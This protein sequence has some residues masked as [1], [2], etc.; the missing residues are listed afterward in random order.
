V[1]TTPAGREAWRLIGELWFG[2][3]MQERFHAA[4]ATAAISPPQLKALLSLEPGEGQ[5]MRALA[6]TWHCDASWVT[7]LVDG[8]EQRGYVERQA[9]P[10][11]RRIKAVALTPLGEKIK[12]E[13]LAV[14]HE[15]PPSLD[16]LSA[17]EQSDLRDLMAKV[18]Q[19]ISGVD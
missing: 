18:A 11:D 8:L 14:L 16:A 9:H 7:G 3:E 2:G 13:A 5:P 17:T 1:G 12:A 6:D 10:K 15:P 19:Y 4:C